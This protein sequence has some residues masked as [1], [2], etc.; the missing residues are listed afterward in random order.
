[1]ADIVVLHHALGR[2]PGV[3]GF[4]AELTAAGHTVTVPDL[5]D[6]RTFDTVEAGVAHA[7]SIGFPTVVERAALAVAGLPPE[8]VYLGFSLGVVPAQQLAQTR[9]GARGAVLCHACIP[10]SEFGGWPPGVPVRVHAAEHDPYFTGDGD[11]AAARALVA[12]VPDAQLALYPGDG[13]LFAEPASPDH[14]PAAA[15][16]LRVRVLQFL[17]TG[18]KAG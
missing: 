18:C 12:E 4:A 2:T 15:A 8:Q 3:R 7:Q 11:A 13:H 17:A 10:P 9:A 5:F 6:G 1:M 16:V 14:D